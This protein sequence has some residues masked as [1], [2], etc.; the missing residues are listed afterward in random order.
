[1]RDDNQAD[2]NQI[3][4]DALLQ[5]LAKIGSERKAAP[6]KVHGKSEDLTSQ[7]LDSPSAIPSY[8][9]G[10]Q[11][12]RRRFVRD[13][14]VVVEHHAQG[15]LQNRASVRSPGLTSHKLVGSGHS[16]YEQR[17]GKPVLSGEEGA[18]SHARVAGR[19]NPDEEQEVRSL[20]QNIRQEQRRI[21][22]MEAETAELRS[23]LKNQ[24][25]RLAHYRLQV[26]ELGRQ[27]G[28]Q[29]AE[30]LRLRAE[31]RQAEEAKKPVR[32]SVAPSVEGRRRG[33]PR[34]QDVIS[35]I[36]QCEDRRSEQE[37]EPQPVQWW[38]D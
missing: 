38:A 9:S 16:S 12:R 4:E 10:G 26:E 2:D 22:D 28:V 14:C 3:T 1:M 33:R 17:P 23:R 21:R 27:L 34:K 25:T 24:E 30:T 8:N 7:H 35:T 19:K 37:E 18:G 15:R 20:R 11:N 31:L 29:Q 36:P 5:A 13:D 6:F 32:H